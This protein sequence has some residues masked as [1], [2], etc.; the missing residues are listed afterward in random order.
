MSATIKQAILALKSRI[1]DAYTAISA[2]GGTLPA[3]QDSA[4]LPAAIE[5]IPSG[6]DDFGDGLA[7]DNTARA[8]KLFGGNNAGIS[9]LVDVNGDITS[10]AAGTIFRVNNLNKIILPAVTSIPAGAFVDCPQLE[11]LNLPT[12]TTINSNSSNVAFYHIKVQHLLL[13]ELIQ[14]TFSYFLFNNSTTEDMSFPKLHRVWDYFAQYS[15]VQRIYVPLVNGF[16]VFSLRGSIN[17][18]DIEC[19][20]NFT[21]DISLTAW[22]PTEAL[23]SGSSSL[24]KPGETFANNLEKLL[25]NLRTHMAANLPTITQGYSIAFS[26]AVKAAI[27]ADTA[28]S[29][30]FTSRG[31]VIA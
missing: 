5:S 13:P 2:K 17:L 10:W 21:S 23:K 20:Q 14:S 4:S 8:I 1:S 11:V 3:T 12:V 24:V 25:Y 29:D 9:E 15:T 30:A 18:I 6:G 19:G 7:Y 22:S 26:S 16:G 27:Q 28:T 31:W